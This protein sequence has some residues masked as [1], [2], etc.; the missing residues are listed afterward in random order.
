[1]H[2]ILCPCPQKQR[3]LVVVRG[4]KGEADSRLYQAPVFLLI[5]WKRCTDRR[6]EPPSVWDPEQLE[7][8]AGHWP[9]LR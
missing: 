6:A 4:G 5:T 2:G 8:H 9:L 3:Y 7:T 1:M